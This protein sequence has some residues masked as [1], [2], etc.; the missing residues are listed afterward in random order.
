MS[1]ISI[2]KQWADGEVLLEADLDYIKSGIETFLNTTGISDDNIQNASI[3]ASSKLIDSTITAAKLATDSVTTIKILAENVTAA[4]LAS[5][6]VTTT[7]IL[8]EN[9][10]AAKLASDSVT[11]TKILAANVTYAKLAADAKYTW[12][13]I[14]GSPFTSNG[15]FT[16]DAYTT[17]IATEGC[18]GGGGGAGSNSGGSP[19]GFGGGQGSPR[20]VFV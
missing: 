18:G 14:T 1:T 15:S 12:T 5:D 6:S 2:Q 13:E 19:G 7:K 10:T 20:Q 16:T 4:K 17:M 3:T 8:A 9:V 11:T